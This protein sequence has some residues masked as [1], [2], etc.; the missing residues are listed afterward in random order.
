MISSNKLSLFPDGKSNGL[1]DIPVEV[2]KGNCGC[3]S[4]NTLS[5]SSGKKLSPNSNAGLPRPIHQTARAYGYQCNNADGS[6][7]S[8]GTVVA[9]DDTTAW[10]L[11]GMVQHN[12]NILGD[13]EGVG[14]NCQLI[15]N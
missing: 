9:G 4:L 6:F 11:V 14:V 12:I 5:S 1:S 13:D 15:Y 2:S 3:S 7:Y 10:A 8:S